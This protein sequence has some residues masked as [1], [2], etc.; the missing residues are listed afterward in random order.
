MKVFENSKGGGSNSSIGIHFANG[1]IVI[2]G[3]LGLC[4]YSNVIYGLVFL[5]DGG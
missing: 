1:K 2:T 5:L 4:P 3:E